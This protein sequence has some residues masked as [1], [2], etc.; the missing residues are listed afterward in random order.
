[1]A[2]KDWRLT[3]F[4]AAWQDAVPQPQEGKEENKVSESQL[5]GVAVV[6]KTGDEQYVRY[7]PAADVKSV[8]DPRDRFRILLWG[9]IRGEEKENK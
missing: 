2:G 8:V 9:K 6:V 5:A 7:L 4:M 3:D 1:M